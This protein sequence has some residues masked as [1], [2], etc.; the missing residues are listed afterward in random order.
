M[1]LINC[2]VELKLKWTKYC[3]LSANSNN[4]DWDNDNG[5]NIVFIIKELEL[6]GPV[7]TLLARDNQKLSKRLSK[8]IERSVYLGEYETKK[9]DKNTTKE[10]RYFLETNFVGVNRLFILVYSYQDDNRP[11]RISCFLHSTQC[12]MGLFW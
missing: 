1:S 11:Y 4:N 5:N 8:V 9:D 6:Y 7:V 2:K 3:V 10:F 12:I